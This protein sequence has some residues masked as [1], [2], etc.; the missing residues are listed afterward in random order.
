LT[1]CFDAPFVIEGHV[2]KGLAS[3]GIAVY[4]EDGV[5]K[6]ALLNAADASMYA[7]KNARHEAEKAQ[8]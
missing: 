7:I 4:P 5:T 1:G 2:I 6:D 8:V 3:I